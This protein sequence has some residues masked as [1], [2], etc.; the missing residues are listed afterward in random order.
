[1]KRIKQLICLL[2]FDSIS[3]YFIWAIVMSIS[4]NAF[5]DTTDDQINN[6]LINLP[7]PVTNISINKARGS[8]IVIAHG[9]NTIYTYAFPADPYAKRESSS[10]HKDEYFYP[11]RSDAEESS[12]DSADYAD[13]FDDFRKRNNLTGI[14]EGSKRESIKDPSK[15]KSIIEELKT[16]YPPK[17]NVDRN[18]SDFYS[19]FGKAESTVCDILDLANAPNSYDALEDLIKFEIGRDPEGTFRTEFNMLKNYVM[20]YEPDKLDKFRKF[21]TENVEL[22]L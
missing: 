17:T 8:I 14:L 3:L 15:L 13:I 16:L 20:L 22:T 18:A 10:K 7:E 9:K 4:L 12:G 21:L 5:A 19:K 11:S 6:Y 2:I 1:M